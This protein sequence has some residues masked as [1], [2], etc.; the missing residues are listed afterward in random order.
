AERVADFYA[1]G[2]PRTQWATAH[3]V[4]VHPLP[5]GLRKFRTP[6]GV[7]TPPS[8]VAWGCPKSFL[9][10]G[11]LHRRLEISRVCHVKVVLGL[12]GRGPLS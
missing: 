5:Y 9:A 4:T 1:S 7:D 6:A 8:W 12:S 3:G 10:L 2:Q 11:T